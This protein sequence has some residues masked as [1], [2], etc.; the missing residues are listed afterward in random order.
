MFCW[1]LNDPASLLPTV[2]VWRY[3][4]QLTFL[5]WDS[6]LSG[7]TWAISHPHSITGENL[8]GV[9]G[10]WWNTK[11]GGPHCSLPPPPLESPPWHSS[12]SVPQLP[13]HCP[14]GCFNWSRLACPW[15][16][17][18]N[19]QN[20]SLA[21]LSF[22]F[23]ILKNHSY[24]TNDLMSPFLTSCSHAHTNIP[25]SRRQL[26]INHSLW[27]TFTYHLLARGPL[28]LL[29]PM[30]ESPRG[31]KEGFQDNATRKK[32]GSLLLNRARAFCSNHHSGAGSESPEQRRLPKFIRY[33]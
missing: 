19:S 12:G 2:I 33:A 7:I 27:S 21:I 32:K 29:C 22:F 4:L 18:P 20:N 13:E 17:A 30:S 28:S 11:E 10:V 23:L 9:K 15:K 16:A 8:A 24:S 14:R 1:G 31:K 26:C 3:F 5:D 25:K 6:A